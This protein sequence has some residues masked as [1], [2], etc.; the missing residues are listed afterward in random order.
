MCDESKVKATGMP[1]GMILLIL[2]WGWVPGCPLWG[3]EDTTQFH[4][5][6]LL[7]GTPKSSLESDVAVLLGELTQ[8]TH[9]DPAPDAWS[10][11]AP[12]EIFSG[13]PFLWIFVGPTT[14]VEEKQALAIHRFISSGGTVM[15]EGSGE[16]RTGALRQL[17]EAVFRK[18]SEADGVKEDDLLTRTFYL[19][20]PE[21]AQS[22]G[23]IRQ[24]ERVVWVET[25]QP[26]LGGLSSSGGLQREH[27]IRSAINVIL[28]ALTGSYKDD[29]THLNYLRRRKR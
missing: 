6:G 12:H 27:R 7:L 28:Y 11:V 15:V 8:R 14:V 1:W 20:R 13:S 9:V 18:S 29:L 3:V 26:L 10:W 25:R 19:L 2:V 17:R 4:L 16:Q 24:A 5:S 21:F 22:L 23:T